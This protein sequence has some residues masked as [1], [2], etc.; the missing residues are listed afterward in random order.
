MNPIT[1]SLPSLFVMLTMVCLSQSLLAQGGSFEF[2]SSSGN[3]ATSR[4]QARQPAAQSPATR[5]QAQQPTQPGSRQIQRLQNQRFPN[6]PA[7]PK[8]ALELNAFFKLVEGTNTG[9]LYLEAKI[10]PGSYIYSTT[11][12]GDLRPSVITALPSVK[13]DYLTRGAFKEMQPAIVIKKDPVMQQRLEKHKGFVRFQTQFSV[14]PDADPRK[15]MAKIQFDGQVCSDQGVCMP[16]RGR[17]VVATFAGYA[18][19]AAQNPAAGQRTAGA[20]TNGAAQAPNRSARLLPNESSRLQ[21]RPATA[22][23]PR[24]RNPANNQGSNNK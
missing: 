9:Y 20:G 4:T 6:Q 1:K 7:K 3:S 5:Q 11:Q 23:Q 16:I 19:P 24:T 14:R 2:P 10:E 18:K 8:Q 15:V 21:R 12:G 17:E 13:G 22:T